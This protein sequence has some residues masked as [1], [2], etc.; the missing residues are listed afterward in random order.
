MVF[1]GYALIND[2]CRRYR[3]GK[4]NIIKSINNSDENLLWVL[5]KYPYVGNFLVLNWLAWLVLVDGT[6]S[7]VNTVFPGMAAG[8]ID[9]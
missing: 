1:R 2:S 9:P 4:C 5:K 7:F 3:R 8:K 6:V